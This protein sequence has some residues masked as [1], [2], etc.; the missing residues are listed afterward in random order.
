[1]L[2]LVELPSALRTLQPGNAEALPGWLPLTARLE[3][4]FA[5]LV[6]ELPGG[7][8]ALLLVAAVHDGD[9]LAEVLDAAAL[10]DQAATLAAL[11]PAVAARLLE[12]DDAGLR[13]RHPLMR[14]A[15]Y[16]AASVA[17]RHAAHAALARTLAGQPDRQIW[18]RAASVIGTD[19]EV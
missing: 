1:P 15:V 2:A 18:H 17:Q 19:E 4:A 7:T 12:L 16:Q 10:L 8:R 9:R 11:E 14:S 5:A 6:A 13:F 3:R